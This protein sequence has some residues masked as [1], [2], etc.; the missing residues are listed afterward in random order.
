MS[1]GGRELGTLWTSARGGGDRLLVVPRDRFTRTSD[2]T[3][4]G[5]R[6]RALDLAAGGDDEDEDREFTPEAL[7]KVLRERWP[8]LDLKTRRMVLRL[9][10][11][12]KF[13]KRFGFPWREEWNEFVVRPPPAP[14]AWQRW[15]RNY[16]EPPSP[17]AVSFALSARGSLLP[18]PK[19]ARQPS[20]RSR[21]VYMWDRVNIM[22][23]A[24]RRGRA[25]FK[26]VQEFVW[27]SILGG[28]W[29]RAAR[30]GD[31][32]EVLRA[33]RTLIKEAI[34]RHGQQPLRFRGAETLEDSPRTSSARQKVRSVPIGAAA[35]REPVWDTLQARLFLRRY[36]F[37]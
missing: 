19:M 23:L 31:P 36:R 18:V 26:T 11:A 30:M 22:G 34:D 20:M 15:G 25:R 10:I 16:T 37:S 2:E 7:P 35:G 27:I 1:G 29:P 8:T 6:D 13:R 28:N 17:I 4:P 21:F 12:N 9:E 32:D 33:E 3:A 14:A 24:P 5:V